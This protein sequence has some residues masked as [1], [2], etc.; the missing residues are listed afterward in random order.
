MKYLTFLDYTMLESAGKNIEAK[1]SEKDKEIEDIRSRF[2]K[3]QSQ[4]QGLISSLGNIK[5]Q[6]QV[7]QMAKTLYNTGIIKNRKASLQKLS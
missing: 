3:M 7:D 1:L 4:M 6:S 5:E 2:D